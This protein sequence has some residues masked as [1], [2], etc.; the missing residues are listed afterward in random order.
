MNFV[1]VY[2]WESE[3]KEKAD[4]KQMEFE[5]LNT[6]G[7]EFKLNTWGFETKL[8]MEEWAIDL[9]IKEC[10]N[11]LFAKH[12]MDICTRWKRGETILCNN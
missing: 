11:T 1:T 12:M 3:G 5:K 6:E 10:P 4:M 7:L 8:V 9:Q 2:R